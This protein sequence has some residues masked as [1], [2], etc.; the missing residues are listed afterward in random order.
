MSRYD[1]PF[2]LRLPFAMAD[3]Y[4]R[5]EQILAADRSRS[6]AQSLPLVA[7]FALSRP[8]RQFARR[9]L[10]QKR[11]YWLFRSNQRQFCG[12]FITVDMSAVIPRRRVVSVIE[13]KFGAELRFGGGGAG[14]Q[15]QRAYAAVREIAL[16]EKIIT[17]DVAVTLI[18]GDGDAVLDWICSRGITAD[19]I[20]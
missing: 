13:L 16:T 20:H 6:W 4:L 19:S 17:S 9:L 1:Q 5:L 7:A 11:N 3:Q 15:L 8:E 10:E 14:N 12:D 18:C 2:T